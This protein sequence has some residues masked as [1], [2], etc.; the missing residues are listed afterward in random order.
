M[1]FRRN[2]YRVQTSRAPHEYLGGEASMDDRPEN[3]SK[4]PGFGHGKL[5]VTFISMPSGVSKSDMT[6]TPP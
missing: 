3:R 2:G 1:I 6:V 4:T 5:T